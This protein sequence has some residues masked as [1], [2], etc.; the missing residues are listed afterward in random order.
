MILKCI[1][2]FHEQDQTVSTTNSRIWY[3]HHW[4][5]TALVFAD[6]DE[7]RVVGDLELLETPPPSPQC[8]LGHVGIRKLFA[9]R[10]LSCFDLI[11]IV[12]RG[13]G[14]PCSMLPTNEEEVWGT[15]GCF[16]SEVKR[17]TRLVKLVACS[18]SP[19]SNELGGVCDFVSQSKRKDADQASKQTIHVFSLSS[20]LVYVS[21]LQIGCSSS[22]TSRS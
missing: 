5:I 13:F 18:I 7:L 2:T 11:P 12:S 3:P 8:V 15:S 20:V 10:V 6:D 19:D 22:L 9:R 14:R 17:S 4:Q 16:S 21:P 1:G